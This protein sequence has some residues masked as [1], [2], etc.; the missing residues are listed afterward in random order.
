MITTFIYNS[1]KVINLMKVFTN[2]IRDL[3][4]PCI[5]QFSTQFILDESFICYETDMKIMCIINEWHE[6]NKDR[7]KKSLKDKV[8]SLIL[9]NQFW[10]KTREVQNIMKPLIK[11]LKLVD[12]DKNKNKN[13]NYTINH[14]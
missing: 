3:L 4:R 2:N 10:I 8:F 6:F 12:Q 11:V 7:S 13:K 9:T 14:L 1:L 5:T